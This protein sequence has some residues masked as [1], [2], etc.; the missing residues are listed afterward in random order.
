MICDKNCFDCPYPDC[1]CNDCDYSDIEDIDKELDHEIRYLKA[2]YNGTLKTFK[3]NHSESG[4]RARQK[5]AQSEKG[6]E[7]E[8]RKT[9]KKIASGKNAEACRRYRERKKAMLMGCNYG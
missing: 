3:A 7:R 9:Q 4:R 6:K 5:Y 2:C 8:R 1:I